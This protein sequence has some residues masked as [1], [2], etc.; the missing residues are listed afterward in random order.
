MSQTHIIVALENKEY[1]AAHELL[2]K[3]LYRKTGIIL[4]EKKKQIA[5]KSYPG[6]VLLGNDEKTIFNNSRR[7]AFKEKM[8]KL[9]SK[10]EK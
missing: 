8:K 9:N 7:Q 6:K 4:E 5:A 1:L 10:K 2:E 3:S